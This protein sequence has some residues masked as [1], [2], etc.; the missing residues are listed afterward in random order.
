MSGTAHMNG[1]EHCSEESSTA[2]ALELGSLKPHQR[3]RLVKGGAERAEVLPR[4]HNHRITQQAYDK[5]IFLLRV[6]DALP[7][8]RCVLNMLLLQKKG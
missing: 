3:I 5:Y 6:S 4:T 2:S 8:V 7:G 1:Q